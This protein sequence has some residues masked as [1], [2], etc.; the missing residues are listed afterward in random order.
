MELLGDVVRWLSAGEHWRGDD[1]IPHRL[2]EHVAM[3]GST[4]LLACLIALPVALWLGHIG[5]GGVLAVNVSNAGRAIPSF[6]ILVFAVQL[7]GIG[8]KPAFVALLALAIPPILTNGYVAMREV[9]QDV[10]EAARGMG[11]TGRQLLLRVEAPLAVPLVMAGIRTS[12]VN[13]VATATLAAF[14][15]WGGLGRFIEDGRAQGDQ[16]M[17]VSGAVLVA[18]L[19]MST[20]VAL[21]RLQKRVSPPGVDTDAKAGSASSL[22]G[23]AAATTMSTSEQKG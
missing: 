4:V 14:V 2:W 7:F 15:G 9:D 3:S 10:R 17:L 20:E 8:S 22:P 19:A 12:A 6:A 5:R 1:G 23:V 16:A 13:V 21:G 18:V 11:M